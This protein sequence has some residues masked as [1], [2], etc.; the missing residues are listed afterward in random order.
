M[1]QHEAHERDCVAEHV[2]VDLEFRV[3]HVYDVDTTLIDR[4]YRANDKGGEANAK[5]INILL[6]FLD[7]IKKHARLLNTIDAFLLSDVR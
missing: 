1:V 3:A 5:E 6:S 7:M 4:F 2:E